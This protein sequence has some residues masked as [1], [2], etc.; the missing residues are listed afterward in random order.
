[1]ALKLVTGPDG[2]PIDLDQAKSH[3][4][5][6]SDDFDD[7]IDAFIEAATS[8]ADGPGGYLGRALIDQTWDLYLDAFPCT[9]WEGSRRVDTIEIPLPPLIEV[10]GVF[11]LDGSGAEQTFTASSYTVDTAS[12]PARI[13][14]KSGSSWPTVQAAANAVRVRFRAGYIDQTVSPAI[15]A[16]PGTI[17][18]ALLIMVADL[19]YNRESTVVGESVARIPWSAEALLRRHRIYLSLA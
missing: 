17:K 18:A 13:V 4:R 11:Y 9:K 10:S 15:D 19:F 3:L 6:D 7:Q 16:V 14:L 12:E 2:F 1:M 8:Y 5:E